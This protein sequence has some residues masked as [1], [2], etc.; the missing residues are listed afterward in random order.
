MM[1]ENGQNLPEI[2]YL[3]HYPTLDHPTDKF[4]LDIFISNYPTE[5]HFDVLNVILNIESQHGG[6]ERIK[7]THPWL[8][9]STYRFSPG[10]VILEDRFGKKEEAFC[11][12]GQITINK[13]DSLSECFL[14]SPAPILQIDA[15]NPMKFLLIERAEILL[16]EYRAVYANDQDF[17]I[18]LCAAD[19][20]ILYTAC[21]ANL[22]EEVRSKPYK[23]DIELQFLSYLQKEMVRLQT[24]GMIKEPV[25]CLDAIFTR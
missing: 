2:G 7:I 14:V 11:F 25:S 4:R 5:K 24:A 3:Y 8:Y 21:L 17:E 19:P 22:L 16:A 23:D 12:G 13:K 15:N 9:Q 18:D 6:F 1:G 20:L 10:K